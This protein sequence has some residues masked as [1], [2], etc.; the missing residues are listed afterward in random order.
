LAKAMTKSQ[1]VS[2]LATKAGIH[3]KA[4]AAV[5]DE[6]AA[7][8]TKESK[9]S[10]QFIIPGLRKA[11]KSRGRRR[12]G[13]SPQPSGVIRIRRASANSDEVFRTLATTFSSL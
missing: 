9:S 7:L 13:L 12:A 10:G 3:K 5:L 4:A 2:H 8:A 1:I 6:I 11:T